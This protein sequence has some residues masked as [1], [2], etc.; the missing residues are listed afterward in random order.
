[1]SLLLPA[2]ESDSTHVVI[3][4]EIITWAFWLSPAVSSVRAANSMAEGL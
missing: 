2:A 4:L 1:M 3:I